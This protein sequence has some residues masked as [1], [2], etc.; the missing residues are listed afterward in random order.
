MIETLRRAF[1]QI[2]A[3]SYSTISAVGIISVIL[4]VSGMF[5]LTFYNLS[6]FVETLKRDMQVIVYFDRGVPPET[7]QGI[8]EEIGR[9]REVEE[10]AYIS[11]DHALEMLARDIASIKEM[12]KGLKENPLPDSFRISLRNYART[13]EGINSLIAKLKGIKGIEDIDYGEEWVERIN[14]LINTAKIIGIIVGAIMILVAL[15]IVHST[16]RFAFLTRREEIKVMKFAGATNA[17]IKIPFIIEGGIL[18]LISAISAIGMLFFTYKLILYKIP[19][20][21][22]IWLRG[23]EFIFI[24]W[25]AAA[26]L[27]ATGV[28]LGCFGGW[29]SVGRYVGVA[30]MLFLCLNINS[31]AFAGARDV[32]NID[33]PQVIEKEIKKS[34]KQLEDIKKEIKKKE[35]ASK[36][37]AAEEKKI[38][39]NI[40]IKK[41][42]LSSKKKEL[43]RV[44]VNIAEKEREIEK[45]QS[46]MDVITS[47]IIM[48]KR[49]AEEFLR[50]V[51]K[52]HIGKQRGIAEILLA[53]SDYHDFMMRSKYEDKLIVEANRIIKELKREVDALQG[54][55][56]LLN[57][58]HSALL[59]EKDKLADGKAKVEKDVR[60]NRVK[61]ASVQEKKARYE[62]DLKRLAG[63]SAA[64][65]DL[66]K[67]YEKRRS[68]LAAIGAGFKKKK[69][70][71]MWP[72]KGEVVSKFGRQKHP[73][74]DAYI[75][76]KGIEI[77]SNSEKDVRAVYNGVVAYADWLKG[78]GLIVIIDH[79]DSYYSV[80]G[81]VSRLL[82]SQGSKIKE[83]QAIAVAGKDNG[84]FSE[85]E[86]VYFEIRYNDQPVDPLAWLSSGRG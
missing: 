15:F 20:T 58:R 23:I 31:I 42:D 7:L 29:V 84:N 17:F 3:N 54:Q 8:K 18:G 50:Y 22:Y 74:F 41:R 69:G 11:K 62:K 72:L 59:A 24:P 64:L 65:K 5:L 16:I 40:A 78:F 30:I 14:A 1:S 2:K 27:I 75:Y 67:S 39:Q 36:R 44:T 79:G 35:R 85:R 86:G 47:D 56:F 66:I 49:K 19:A 26:I 71:L 63:T 21:A 82:V 33:T 10:I 34:Q 70:K 73:E 81:H 52:S 25:E 76:R 46:D 32:H 28:F 60:V 13:P 68:E 9:F 51:Y 38:K 80:Y 6:I 53:S 45:V 61:L 55:L 43:K 83:G 57:K 12:V 4:L 48:K 77:A 37:A